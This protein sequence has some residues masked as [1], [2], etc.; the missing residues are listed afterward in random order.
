MQHTP[1]LEA[2]D[3]RGQ[4]FG[5]VS[6]SLSDGACLGV[7]GPSGAG[8]SRMLRAMVDLDPHEGVVWLEGQPRARYTGPQWRRRVGYVPADSRWWADTVA[9]HFQC[10]EALPL[11]DLGLEPDLLAYPSHRLSSGERQRLALLRQWE[12]RPQ[13]LLLDEP[14]ANLDAQGRERFEAFVLRYQRQ[15]EA[16]LLWVSHDREQLLRVADSRVGMRRGRLEAVAP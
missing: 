2:R 7:F 4:G 10:P 16:A 3:L 9:A 8:K 5:P 11:E 1:V 12:L 15:R 6:L 13:V 14:T